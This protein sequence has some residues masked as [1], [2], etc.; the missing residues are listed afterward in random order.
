MTSL[1]SR[2]KASES[3]FEH[4]QSNNSSNCDANDSGINTSMDFKQDFRNLLNADFSNKE[5]IKQSKIILKL[6]FIII[7]TFVCF[8][9]A[10]L[11][12]S[13]SFLQGK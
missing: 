7:Y 12:G 6:F 13:F 4:F 11:S 10:D 2:N 9:E 1:V 8:C 3:S 5:N